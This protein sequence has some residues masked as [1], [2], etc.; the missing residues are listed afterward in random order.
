M[1][2]TEIIK[3]LDVFGPWAVLVFLSIAYIRKDR[4]LIKSIERNDKL[5]EKLLLVIENKT[6]SDTRLES[7]LTG[8]RDIIMVMVNQ[9]T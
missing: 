8:L 4:Q 5:A 6:V 1:G 3:A 7:A 2:T 9:I